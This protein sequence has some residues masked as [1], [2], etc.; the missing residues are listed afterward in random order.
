[1]NLINHP[2]NLRGLGSLSAN[3]PARSAVVNAARAKTGVISTREATGKAMYEQ[4]LH[5][6]P[7]DIQTAISVG[8]LQ[9]VD[10]VFYSIKRI[11]TLTDVELM[12]AADDKIEG[13]TNV[14]RRKIEANKW[15]LLCGIQL[16]SGLPAT[17]TASADTDKE[18]FSSAAFDLCDFR[19]LN[20]EFE[21]KVGSRVIVPNIS[22]A[23]FDTRGRH[24]TLTGLWEEFDPQFITPNTEIIP[25]LKLSAAYEAPAGSNSA[26]FGVFFAMHCVSAVRN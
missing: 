5:Y 16:L 9:L 20:G 17:A 12:A 23:V 25:R 6:L 14:D 4:M 22:C 10:E 24:N 8:Q 19:I 21:L 18:K 15:S 13:V 26:N 11:G 1:M 3:N 7:E 2:E